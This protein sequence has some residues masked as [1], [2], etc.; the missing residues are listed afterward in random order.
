MTIQ[1]KNEKFK[2]SGNIVTKD[3]IPKMSKAE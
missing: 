1:S 2:R 3:K